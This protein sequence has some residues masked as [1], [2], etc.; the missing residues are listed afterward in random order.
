MT[1]HIR[2]PTADLLARQLAAKLNT[3]VT[4]AV[5]DALRERLANAPAHPDS[6]EAKLARVREIQNKVAAMPILDHRSADEILGYDE[7]GLPT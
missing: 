3:S 4:N 7:N 6:Y 1:L 5:I 2:N